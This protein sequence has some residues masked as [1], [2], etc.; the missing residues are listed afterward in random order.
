MDGYSP[1]GAR[2]GLSSVIAP[3]VGSAEEAIDGWIGTFY[4][5][6]PLLEPG[7]VRIGWG[8]EGHVAVLDS[9]SLVAPTQTPMHVAWPPPQAVNV[10]R[11]FCAELP[12]PV[13]GADQSQWG[14]PV[15]L[16]TFGTDP[17][18]R[19]RLYVGAQRGG[20]EIPC[21]FSTPKEPTNTELAPAGAFCLIPKVP[22]AA[23][24]T[25]T[26]AVDGWVKEDAG[27]DWQFTTGK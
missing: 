23:N 14:Y 26:V 7:L 10:P 27:A 12:N 1:A 9:G 24:T 3:G 5:R 21:H 13:P 20:T 16:Q 8:L 17:Q 22:L 4:H 19:M 15:T 25:Y 2:S 11:R 6:L 18:L